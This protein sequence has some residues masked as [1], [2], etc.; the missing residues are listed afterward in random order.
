MI[1]WHSAG[2]PE[3]DPA[4]ALRLVLT[5]ILRSQVAAEAAEH[6]PAP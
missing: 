4:D 5:R 2:P 6:A 3:G 1:A